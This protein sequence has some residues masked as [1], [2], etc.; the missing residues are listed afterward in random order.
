MNPLLETWLVA[1]RDSRKNVRSIKGLVMLGISLLGAFACTFKLPKFEDLMEDVKKLDAD[2]I[3]QVKIQFFSKLY[4]DDGAG[5]TLANAPIKLVILFFI[6]VWL[7]P[8]LVMIIGFDGV[9]SDLQYRSVRYWTVRTRRPSYYAGKFLAL[10]G[11]IGLVTLVMQALIWL[12][13]IVRAEATPADTLSW[14]LRFWL[15]SLPITGAW[16]GL[17]TLTGSLFRVPM[18]SL[19]TTGG[20]FFVLFFLGYIIGKGAD[21]SYLRFLYPNNFDAWMLSGKSERVLEGVGVCV[22]YMLVTSGAGAAVFM[23]RDV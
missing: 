12:V 17:A 13:T 2:Q 14:G 3:R 19:L 7:V 8:L 21:V 18:L 16:C 9:S 6:A 15:V 4:A 10:W 22:A 5:E 1:A 20:T 23:Q 11:V